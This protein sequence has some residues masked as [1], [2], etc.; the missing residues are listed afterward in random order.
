MN[1]LIVPDSFKS[2]LSSIKVA[3][4]ISE[5]FKSDG[6]ETHSVPIGDGGEGT[7]DA[8]LYSLGGEKKYIEVPDP[9][10]RQ[11]KT[12]YG[13]KN[14]TAFMEIS[15]ASGLML[16]KESEYDPART[17]TNGFGQ[18]ITDAVKKGAE[19][20]YLGLGGTATNDAGIGMLSELGV[21]FY[22][23]SGDAIQGSLCGSML[24][25][26]ERIDAGKLNTRLKDIEFI[27]ISDVQNPLTGKN[28]ATRIFS[29][30]KGADSLMVEK[31][32]EGMINYAAIIKRDFSFDSGFPGAGAAGGVGAS[33]KVFLNAKITPGIE[34]VINLLG[35]EKNIAE[36]DLVIVGEGSL[37]YQS[38]FGKAPVGIARIAKKYNKNVIAIA[39]KLGE[40][41]ESLYN[42]GIDLIFSYYGNVN[43]NLDFIQKNSEKMLKETAS[44]AKNVIKTNPNL[45][46]QKYI[47]YETENLYNA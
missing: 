41:A 18:M 34:C 38:A 20:I 23:K 30:Q 16:I 19:K 28:G 45:K 46:N 43:V 5:V 42:E 27:I 31:L 11:I 44:L 15:K 10:G 13:M 3:E 2:T 22:D 35:L 24:E 25:K 33:L 12:Y 8:L 21:K 17:T 32:E 26:I 47:I 36:S 1:V 6:F 14:K 37:D 29:P 39:G 9:F 7:V 4:I 40:N